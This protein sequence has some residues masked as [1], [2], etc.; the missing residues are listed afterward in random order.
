MIGDGTEIP[1]FQN[2]LGDPGFCPACPGTGTWLLSS[3]DRLVRLRRFGSEHVL[4]LH[5]ALVALSIR[6]LLRRR[7]PALALVTLGRHWKKAK[8]QQR[9]DAAPHREY[10]QGV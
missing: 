4:R 9:C 8:L 3:V 5:G 2:E 6:A 7:R 10:A 1:A